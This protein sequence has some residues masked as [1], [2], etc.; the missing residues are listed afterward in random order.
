LFARAHEVVG[1]VAIFWEDRPK[2]DR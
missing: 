1:A 2:G